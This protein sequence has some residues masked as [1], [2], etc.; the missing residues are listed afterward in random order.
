M[1]EVDARLRHDEERH[2]GVLVTAELGAL[3][4]IDSNRISAEP[5]SGFVSGYEIFLPIEVGRPK[6]VNDI[7]RRHFDEHRSANGNVNLVRRLDDVLRIADVGVFDFPPPLVSDHVYP[8]R[9]HSAHPS[10]GSRCRYVDEN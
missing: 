2:L 3:S 1:L 5:G 7:T 10:Q 6:T 4:P 8:Q 9:P